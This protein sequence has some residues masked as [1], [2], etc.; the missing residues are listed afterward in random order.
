MTYVDVF[1]ITHTRKAPT[2]NR[3]PNTRA[4]RLLA[5]LGMDRVHQRYVGSRTI[6]EAV[7]AAK[8]Q[9]GLDFIYDLADRLDAYFII[10]YSTFHTV[11]SSGNCA[12]ARKALGTL[13]SQAEL[14]RQ[15]PRMDRES[16]AYRREDVRDE[17]DLHNAA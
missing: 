11:L 14:E 1:G 13:P 15:V 8:G 12:Q 10:P 9:K 17:L 7:D 4:Q 6:Q 2:T 5:R 16:L 3:L